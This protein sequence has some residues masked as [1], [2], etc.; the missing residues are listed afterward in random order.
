MFS[1]KYFAKKSTHIKYL[2]PAFLGAGQVDIF[3]QILHN[4]TVDVGK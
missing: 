3:S 2:G 1:L 4:K